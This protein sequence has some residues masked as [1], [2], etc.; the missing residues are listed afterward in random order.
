MEPWCYRKKQASE[1]GRKLAQDE[2]QVVVTLGLPFEER[3]QH[4]TR[5]ARVCSGSFQVSNEI[6]L[7]ADVCI[8]LSDGPPRPLEP[9]GQF[10]NF[11]GR[12]HATTDACIAWE[13]DV[14]CEAR[15][16]RRHSSCELFQSMWRSGNAVVRRH[17]ACPGDLAPGRTTPPS[18]MAGTSPAITRETAALT[19]PAGSCRDP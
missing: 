12:P 7:M 4:D 8:A 6:M 10:G 13:H 3:V 9:V 16:R 18:E 17:R 1:V 19:S 5:L 2:S 14:V 11:H 15:V